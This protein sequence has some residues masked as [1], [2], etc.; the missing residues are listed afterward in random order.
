PP[1]LGPDLLASRLRDAQAHV[2]IVDTA[3]GPDVL[4]AQLAYPN[5]S[6]II[7]LGFQHENIIPWRTLLVRQPTIFKPPLPTP[8]SSPAFL[9]YDSADRSQP[10]GALLAHSSLI[11][12]LPGFVSSQN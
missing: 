5:L 6:Q 10:L 11:G 1:A 8:S 2:A 4:Q 9:L 12:N 7:G 3:A